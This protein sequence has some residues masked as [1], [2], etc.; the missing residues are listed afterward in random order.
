MA[1]NAPWRYRIVG[2]R[3]EQPDQLLANPRNW[4][5]HP[6]EQQRR[7]AGSLGDVGWVAQVLV[8]RTSG[9]VIDGHARIEEA[10]GRGE[11]SV[12]VLYVD[13]SERRRAL[14]LATLDPLG[15]HGRSPSRQPSPSCWPSSSV[16]DAGL[17][18]LLADLAGDLPKAGLTDPDEAPAASGRAIRQAG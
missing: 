2:S 13:L 1:A 15:R 12:P 18:A 9:H 17:A 3:Q 4:R 6:H 11:P 16:E 5:R 8:N 10:I 14:V 7:P